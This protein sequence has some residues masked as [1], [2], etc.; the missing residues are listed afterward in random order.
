MHVKKW[1]LPIFFILILVTSSNAE[2]LPQ[3]NCKT[4]KP[5]CIEIDFETFVDPDT[6][7][8]SEGYEFPY[9][10]K[11]GDFLAIRHL[12]VVNNDD[13]KSVAF[14]YNVQIQPLSYKNLDEDLRKVFSDDYGTWDV[15]VPELEPGETYSIEYKGNRNWVSYRNEKVEGS[16]NFIRVVLYKEGEWLIKEDATEKKTRKQFSSYRSVIQN[17]WRGNV[18][19]VNPPFDITTLVKVENSINIAK[20]ALVITLF[21][22]A[23]DIYFNIKNIKSNDKLHASIRESLV[24]KKKSE[25]KRRTASNI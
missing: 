24:T 8:L 11:Q 13:K 2:D 18:F 21:G 3:Y 17:K 14:D 16:P 5:L 12:R 25:K 23:V 10:T 4:L 20:A 15:H 19:Q 22:L 7:K 6:D 1:L 9:Y